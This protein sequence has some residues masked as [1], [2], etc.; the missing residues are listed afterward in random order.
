[1]RFIKK[2][3]PLRPGCYLFAMPKF[4]R[5]TNW[6]EEE[7]LRRGLTYPELAKKAGVSTTS[8]WE[9]CGAKRLSG[10]AALRYSVALGL[11]LEKLRP[12]LFPGDSDTEGTMSMSTGATL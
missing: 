7:R 12:D 6:L 10:E 2:L 4:K 8:A 11:P 1:M 3:A 5:E 9:H